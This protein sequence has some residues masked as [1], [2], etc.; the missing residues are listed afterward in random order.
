MTTIHILDPLDLV[1]IVPYQLGFHPT[2]SLVVVGLRG[3]RVHVV[4]R[5]DL[6]PPQDDE[7]TRGTA[8]VVS[9][10][11]VTSGCDGAVVVVYEDRPGHGAAVA[12]NAAQSLSEAGLSLLGPIVVRDGRAYFSGPGDASDDGVPLPPQAQ[13]PAIAD[14]VAMGRHPFESLEE[15]QASLTPAQDE[16]SVALDAAR[17]AAPRDHPVPD[18]ELAARGWGEL[19]DVGDA[20]W[21]APAQPHLAT[22]VAML[23]SLVDLQF[24]DLLVAWLSPGTLT[25]DAFDRR[26]LELLEHLPPDPAGPADPRGDP[27]AHRRRESAAR[28]RRRLNRTGSRPRLGW[29]LEGSAELERRHRL[30]A[31]LVWLARHAPPQDRAAVSSVLAGYAWH[32]GDGTLARLAL[33]AALQADPD[34]R[35]ARLL[36][37]M[38]ELGLRPDR[39]GAAGRLRAG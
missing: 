7:A 16:L 1:M 30:L 3:K 32:I 23:T 38:V 25:L 26:L 34:Y 31:R 4:Q 35:L 29:S 20:R 2:R 14:F 13:V 36:Q 33:D 19:F 27:A 6:P 17:R 21:F 10:H 8:A 15:L 11:T 12:A 24:R 28:R 18:L 22:L 37:H 9:R 39:V 5:C